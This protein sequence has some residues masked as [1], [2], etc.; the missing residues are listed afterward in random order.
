M[1]NSKFKRF[2][3]VMVMATLVLS[4]T[5]A[6][7]ASAQANAID[8]YS[9]PFDVESGK[10]FENSIDA[11]ISG[12][13]ARTTLGTGT[14]YHS[15]PLFG[16]P[17][18]YAYTEAN[19]TSYSVRAKCDVNNNGTGTNS[20][21]WKSVSNS[22]AANSGTIKATTSKCIFDG[23]HEIQSTST[24]AKASTQTTASYN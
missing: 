7:G 15:N 10:M 20:T 6:I 14:L 16:K 1:K 11:P 22:K 24:S 8:P 4:M 18:A 2:T 5:F 23:F 9:L 21:G 19:S 17:E 3:S 12:G 13:L